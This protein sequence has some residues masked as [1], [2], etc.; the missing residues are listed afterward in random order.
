MI[1]SNQL[2]TDQSAKLEVVKDIVDGP[3][4]VV[5]LN[6]CLLNFFLCLHLT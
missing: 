6:I 5:I 2:N 4:Q 1:Y 3:F